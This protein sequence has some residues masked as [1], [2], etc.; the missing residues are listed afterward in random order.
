MASALRAPTMQ[1]SDAESEKSPSQCDATV[2]TESSRLVAPPLEQLDSRHAETPAEACAL[3]S[4]RDRIE[5]ELESAPPLV[6]EP[7][8][9]SS[10][11]TLPVPA[12]YTWPH[13]DCVILA[14]HTCVMRH[15]W[16][17]MGLRAVSVAERRTILEPLPGCMHVMGD[18][19]EFMSVYPH[20]PS[21]VDS[22]LTSRHAQGFCPFPIN[23]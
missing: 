8:R 13:F 4:L 7:P 19:F 1:R 17:S 18:I 6:G 23:S 5:A 2:A 15:I 12:G 10:E 22:H 20:E 16:G 11:I 3:R 21:I 14:S 9:F